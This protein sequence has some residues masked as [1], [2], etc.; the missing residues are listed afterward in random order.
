MRQFLFSGNAILV[1]LK[2]AMKERKPRLEF[3]L[4]GVF[5]LFAVFF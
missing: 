2:I 4:I 3:I 1:V 5:I